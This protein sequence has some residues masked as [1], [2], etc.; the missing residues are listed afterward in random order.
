MEDFRTYKNSR[1]S[2]KSLNHE[3][4]RV[5]RII[6][7]NEVIERY[8]HGSTYGLRRLYYLCHE[9]N[10]GFGTYAP[11]WFSEFKQNGLWYKIPRPLRGIMPACPQCRSREHVKRLYRYKKK[12]D[13]K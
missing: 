9:C 5:D 10:I 8:Q 2:Y 7:Y 1:E 13:K 4:I 3:H 6:K 11:Y 12:G